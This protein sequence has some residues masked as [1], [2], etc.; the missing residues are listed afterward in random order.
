MWMT[1]LQYIGVDPDALHFWYLPGEYFNWSKFSDPK[2]SEL[3]KQGQQERD[4]QKR[5]EIYHEAQKIIMDQAVEMP[6]RANID[7]VMTS[8]KLTGLTYVGGGFEYLLAVSLT[9]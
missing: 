5:L 6:I 7:L 1:P 2:L 9:N 4:T 8:K 3:I